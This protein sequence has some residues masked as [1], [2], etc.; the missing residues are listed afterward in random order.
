MD[1]KIGILFLVII[2]FNILDVMTILH[3]IGIINDKLYNYTDEFLNSTAKFS[4]IETCFRMFFILLYILR[5][6]D[7]NSKNDM[8]KFLFICLILDVI[9]FQFRIFMSFSD[10]IALYFGYMIILIVLMKYKLKICL[11]WK[12]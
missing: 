3:D 8:N 4:L 12:Y 2:T 10:R 9:L 7:L 11:M 6:K 1:K 5:F